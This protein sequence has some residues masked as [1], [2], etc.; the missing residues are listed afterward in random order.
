MWLFNIIPN[1]VFH[2]LTVLGVIAF[3]VSTIFPF[4]PKK[5]IVQLISGFVLCFAF[6]GQGVMT[7]QQDLQ[8]KILILE[9]KLAKKETESVKTNIV[10]QK[11]YIDR[12]KTVTEVKWKVKTQ[13][14]EKEKIIDANC[15]V[16]PEVINIL[17]EAAK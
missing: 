14:V 15:V 3:I 10:I 7:S 2:T 9:T 5:T 17:N 13:I 11:E 1:F 4:I 8:Q 16:P 12:V 6:W